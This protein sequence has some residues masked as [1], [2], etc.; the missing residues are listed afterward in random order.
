M[1]KEEDMRTWPD[2]LKTFAKGLN[3]DDKSMALCVEGMKSFAKWIKTKPPSVPVQ[4]KEKPSTGGPRS[5]DDSKD[6][7]PE[8]GATGKLMKK[9]HRKN[10]RTTAGPP[11]EVAGEMKSVVKLTPS[12]YTI[13][14]PVASFGSSWRDPSYVLVCKDPQRSTSLACVCVCVCVSFA[15]GL[16]VG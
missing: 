9:V 13:A 6:E 16:I 1:L 8:L 12:R 4:L 10:R 14:T 15:A 5:H 2:E 7:S 11:Q 3:L